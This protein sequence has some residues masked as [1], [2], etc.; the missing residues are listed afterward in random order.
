MHPALTAA[1]RPAEWVDKAANPAK[2]LAALFLIFE[3]FS[4]KIEVGG[5]AILGLSRLD[6]PL[7]KTGGAINGGA[8]APFILTVDWL[9]W[10]CYL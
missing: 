2:C 9:G 4:P 10:L 8:Y 1:R 6:Y 5:K 7:A 3:C